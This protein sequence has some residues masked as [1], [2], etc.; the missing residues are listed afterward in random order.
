MAVYLLA[1]HGGGMPD[2]DDERGKVMA[3]WGAWFAASGGAIKDPGNPV[4]Q[5]R[6]VATDGTVSPG[7]G[8]NPVSGYTLLEA[9]SMERAVEIAKGCP[10][11]MG[12][13]SIEVAETFNAM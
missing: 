9:D 4:G 10:V 7:G 12:G 6:T 3:A 13:A 11:L 1:Y 5:T 2:S 8:V